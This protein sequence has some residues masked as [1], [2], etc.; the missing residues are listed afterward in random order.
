M[1]TYFAINITY[2]GFLLRTKEYTNSDLLIKQA[3]TRV[4]VDDCSKIQFALPKKY[5]LRWRTLDNSVFLNEVLCHRWLKFRFNGNTIRS[6][7][8]ALLRRR[9]ASHDIS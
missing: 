8:V 1:K 9:S 2:W 5:S 4:K 6:L 7:P 3:C